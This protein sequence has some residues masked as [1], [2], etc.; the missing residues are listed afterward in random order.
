MKRGRR[1]RALALAAACAALSCSVGPEVMRV[2]SGRSLDGR[3]I[4]PEAYAAYLEGTL[5]EAR[6]DLQNARLAYARALS[7][8]PRSAEIWARVGAVQC[9]SDPAASRAAFEHAESIDPAL[10]A[11]WIATA[12][13]ALR[14]GEAALARDAALRA[15][16]LTPD[17]LSTSLLAARALDRSGDAPRAAIWLR[18]LVLRRPASLEAARAFRDQ[19]ARTGNVADVRHARA[20]VDE[21]VER[22]GVPETA[23]PDVGAVDRALMRSDAET[24]RAEAVRARMKTTT[25]ALTALERGRAELARDTATTVLAA[26]P[27]NVDARV[28]LLLAADLSG[29]E[30]SWQ[31]ALAR[32]PEDHTELSEQAS[33]LMGELLSRRAGPAAAA[34]W[35]AASIKV[36]QRATATVSTP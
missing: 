9:D 31:A 3:W 28:A 17:D 21:L 29:D 26:E 22:A 34:A 35:S 30:K 11:P 13:C 24:A 1:L 5:F 2:E 6:G 8:D 4:S 16:A 12:E 19:A 15:A 20:H 25:L 27:E 7:E 32:V 23:E 33:R 10:A 14:R 36:R 18:A